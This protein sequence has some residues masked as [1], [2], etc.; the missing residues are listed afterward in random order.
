MF[1]T[2][3]ISLFISSYSFAKTDCFIAKEKDRVLRLDGDCKKRFAPQSTFKIPLALMGY[4]SG[5]FT[6]EE[7][8]TY[9]YKK[10]YN[11]FLNTCKSDHNPR[12][13]MRDS[14]V[15]FS[16]D[17]TE[18]LGMKKFQD[19]VNK[20]EYGNKSLAGGIKTSWLSSSLLITAEEQVS[21]IQRMLNKN[22]QINSKSYEM[23]KKILFIQ[24][25]AGGWKLYGKTGNGYQK[26]NFQQGWFVGWIEK[27]SRQI[28]FT[29]HI[30]DLAKEKKFASFRS[31]NE[32]SILLWNLI[33]E[34]EGSK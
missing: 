16:Q 29:H 9:V 14:C 26:N 6:S 1:M 24:E 3:I 11:T 19:Y 8:P 31:K 2:L 25:L 28:A 30:T 23:T 33:E 7:A 17:L 20:F 5:L 12:T 34:L 32:A 22:L 27:D 18:K 10:E 13:W 4:D 15:W 21:F